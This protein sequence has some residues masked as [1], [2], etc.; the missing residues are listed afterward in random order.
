[1]PSGERRNEISLVSK[2]VRP[3]TEVPGSVKEQVKMSES[4]VSGGELWQLFP[5]RNV[6]GRG[7]GALCTI[8][9]EFQP[10]EGTGG[11]GRIMLFLVGSCPHLLA[12][13]IRED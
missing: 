3:V 5:T 13:P 7:V 9:G 4:E 8:S 1:L 12:P 2:S 11:S 10:G 6:N